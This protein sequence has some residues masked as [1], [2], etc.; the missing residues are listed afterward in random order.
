MNPNI[1]EMTLPELYNDLFTADSYKNLIPRYRSLLL[2]AVANKKDVAGTNRDP[3]LILTAATEV[4]QLIPQVLG[5]FRLITAKPGDQN[6]GSDFNTTQIALHE[7]M[8]K[9]LY[10][11]NRKCRVL[12]EAQIDYGQYDSIEAYLRM[13]KK[14][15][16]IS[17][18]IM[19]VA[20]QEWYPSDEAIYYQLVERETN[21]KVFDMDGYGICFQIYNEQ[22]DEVLQVLEE[23]RTDNGLA[24][25]QR[26]FFF[27]I[28]QVF[29]HLYLNTHLCELVKTTNTNL[30]PIEKSEVGVYLMEAFNQAGKGI[31]LE[32][33]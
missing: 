15:F 25:S 7:Y 23:M 6:E 10:H 24:I 28:F 17:D 8:I 2:D 20:M 19:L 22:V 12:L 30:D 5:I 11:L 3:E 32:R 4:A 26:Y 29:Q 13:F 27:R 21:L 33:I 14:R 16:G 9:M 18:G 31:L 1:N